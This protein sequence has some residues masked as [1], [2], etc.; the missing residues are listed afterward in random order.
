MTIRE[1]HYDFKQ[2]LNKIDSQKY[3]NLLVPEIDWKLNEAQEVFVKVVAEPRLKN[4]FGFEIN[5]RTID[6]IRTI[7]IN[8]S[9]DKKNCI[10]ATKFDEESYTVELPEDYWFHISSE[11]FGTKGNCKLVKLDTIVR[12]HDD[13]FKSSPFDN[14]SFEWREVNIRFFGNKIRIFTDKTFQVNYLCLD[15]I[16]KPLKLHNAQDAQGGSYRD[17]GTGLLLTGS[18]DCELPAHTHREIVDLAVLITTG[19]LQIS[20]YQIK[21]NKLKLTN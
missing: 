12:Q 3:R 1:M 6:D 10:S 16:K 15:Y 21:Q 20:D 13:R 18:Q 7:V 9:L 2:K 19:D 4:G 14:S 11:V 8:Q 5:Q 17:L